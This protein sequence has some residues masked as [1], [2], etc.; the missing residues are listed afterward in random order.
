MQEEYYG[1]VSAHVAH[2]GLAR[3]TVV[4]LPLPHRNGTITG[5]QTAVL[6]QVMMHCAFPLPR[7]AGS[8]PPVLLGQH[9][10]HPG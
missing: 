3:L 1:K 5:Q 10:L 2:A 4:C 6:L 8:H 9:L 7:L